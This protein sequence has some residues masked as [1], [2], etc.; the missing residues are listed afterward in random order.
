M[1][2]G[3]RCI[4]VT[5][6]TTSFDD[7]VETIDSD[8]FG[9]AAK[10]AGYGRIL[11]QIG[12][13]TYE[14][15]RVEFYRFKPSLDDD[16]AKADLVISHAGA[17]SIMESLRLRRRLLVVVNESLMDNHQWELAGALRDAGHLECATPSIDVMIASLKRIEDRTGS[18]KLAPYPEPD[19]AALKGVIDAELKNANAH[20]FN[21]CSAFAISMIIAAC[22]ALTLAGS[23]STRL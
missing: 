15:K 12:R 9:R 8:E 19:P 1:A 17:G 2:A 7:L 23:A 16:F 20:A 14:P 11:V 4:F 3:T 6:G 10:C 21:L 13:G 18:C 22:A 5:V